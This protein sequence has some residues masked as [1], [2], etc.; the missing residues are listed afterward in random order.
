M[1]DINLS[2]LDWG[3]WG[4]QAIGLVGFV[5]YV[6]SFQILNPRKTIFFQALA[7][8]ILIFHFWGLDRVFIAFLALTASLRDAGSA[9][10]EKAQH[11][12]MMVGYFIALAAG[13]IFLADNYIDYLGVAGSVMS[14]S[15]Q[16]FRSRFYVYRALMFMHQVFWLVV[17]VMIGS[18]PG[19]ITM[20]G[21]FVSNIV[22]IVR[23]VRQQ[24]LEG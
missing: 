21:V 1:G 15:S 14:S 11:R 17:Y 5:L 12:P 19:V 7:N 2:Q 23:Y 4:I 16:F 9:S 18:I 20:S 24:K 6:S 10:L 8:F 13:T 22:G 3:F